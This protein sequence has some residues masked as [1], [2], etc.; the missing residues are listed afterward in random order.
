MSSGA[1]R[2]STAT[3]RR[4][5]SDSGVEWKAIK[6]DN[7]HTWLTEG[8]QVE[9]ETFVPVGSKEAK[10]EKGEAVDVIFKVHSLG[11]STNRDAWVYSFNRNALTENME[12][13]IAFYNEQVQVGT[14]NGSSNQT[15][16]I[17]S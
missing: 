15:S 12:R 4:R 14:T 13:M 1:R 16:M 6:P 8:H 7:R 2:P 17:L 11:V 10:A 3:L 9:F 5:S